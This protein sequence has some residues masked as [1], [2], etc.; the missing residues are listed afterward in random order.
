MM[1]LPYCYAASSKPECHIQV[2]EM[3]YCN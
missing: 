3:C 1:H 2:L